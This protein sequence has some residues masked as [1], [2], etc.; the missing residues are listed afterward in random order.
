MQ[1]LKIVVG[2]RLRR[3]D[4]DGER[5]ITSRTSSS[6]HARKFESDV[7]VVGRIDATQAGVVDFI[8]FILL[9]SLTS[10][11]FERLY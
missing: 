8:Y 9:I 2:M 10:K 7:T 1:S 4:F 5:M 3:H 11:L 6:V